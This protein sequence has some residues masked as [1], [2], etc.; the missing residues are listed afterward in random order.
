MYDP[1][2]LG[3][4][5][6]QKMVVKIYLLDTLSMRYFII[7]VHFLSFKYYNKNI[8]NH[9]VKLGWLHELE[10]ALNLAVNFSSGLI[11]LTGTVQIICWSIITS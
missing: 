1:F 6:S 11:E 9:F 5:I 4:T 8:L 7:F 10:G 2:N 3:Q